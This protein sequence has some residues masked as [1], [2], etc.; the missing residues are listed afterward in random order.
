MDY[1]V[2]FNLEDDLETEVFILYD[3]ILYDD[4]QTEVFIFFWH[5]SNNLL[6]G[7]YLFIC[8]CFECC[9]CLMQIVYCSAWMTTGECGLLMAIYDCDQKGHLA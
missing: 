1:F 7:G 5:K 9:T 6:S 3:I 2:K 4:L 8:F